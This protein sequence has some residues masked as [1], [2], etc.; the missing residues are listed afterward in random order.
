MRGRKQFLPKMLLML[1]LLIALSGCSLNARMWV[2]ENQRWESVIE[3]RYEPKQI[4]VMKLLPEL[5]KVLPTDD[6]P[7]I[8]KGGTNGVIDALMDVLFA[9]YGNQGIHAE[10]GCS[11]MPLM[12][13]RRCLIHLEGWQWEQIESIDPSGS[14]RVVPLSN[15]DLEIAVEG[16]EVNPYLSPWFKEQITIY[17]SKVLQSNAPERGENWARWRNPTKID[18]VLT[19]GHRSAFQ[20]FRV[21][22]YQVSAKIAMMLQFLAVVFVVVVLGWLLW[23]FRRKKID[24]EWGSDSD[25]DWDE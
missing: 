2:Y 5:E 14:I 12:K 9:S 25:W 16:N 18:V 17:G 13:E 19:P 23:H 1:F 6:I 24:A 10:G 11:S 22:W 4:S 7:F 21:W 8:S 15:G 20:R 3:F